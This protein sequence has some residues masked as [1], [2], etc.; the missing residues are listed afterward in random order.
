MEAESSSE[1]PWWHTA[2]VYT[3]DKMQCWWKMKLLHLL[4]PIWNN[5]THRAIKMQFYLNRYLSALTRAWGHLK[6][7]NRSMKSLFQ[8]FWRKQQPWLPTFVESRNGLRKGNEK[9]P[10][11]GSTPW[12]KPVFCPFQLWESRSVPF[13]LH[14]RLWAT[15]TLRCAFQVAQA[16]KREAKITF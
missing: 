6:Y 15:F 5:F 11:Q 4:D 7:S 8:T 10:S 14:L 13:G 12:L 1:V 3:P 9:K 16:W 2:A